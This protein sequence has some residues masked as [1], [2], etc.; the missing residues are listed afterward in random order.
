MR[1]GGVLKFRETFAASL[2]PILFICV[3]NIVP[4]N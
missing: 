2:F 1:D 3:L 4:S